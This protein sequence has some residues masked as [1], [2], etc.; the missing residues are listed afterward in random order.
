MHKNHGIRG[1]LL[2]ATLLL[3]ACGQKGALYLPEPAKQN[4]QQTSTEDK[5]GQQQRN[6]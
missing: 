4:Q 2:V 5:D 6:Q 3:A 1:V